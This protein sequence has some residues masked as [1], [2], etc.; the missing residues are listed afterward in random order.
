MKL[1]VVIPVYNERETIEEI[2]DQSQLPLCALDDD[3]QELL[4]NLGQGTRA[5][6]DERLREAQCLDE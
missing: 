6:F 5:S 4:L 3:P 1:S 2:V